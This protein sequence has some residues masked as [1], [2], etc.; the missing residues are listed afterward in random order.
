MEDVALVVC[1]LAG[2]TVEDEG[3]VPDAFAAALGACGVEVTAE[4]LRL[5][6]GAS[7]REAIRSFIPAGPHHARD[8]QAAYG[9][10]CRLLRQRYSQAGVRPIP[11]A[12]AIFEWLR[13]QDVR[14]ALNTGFDRDITGMLLEAL[15][16]AGGT[17][18]AVVCGDEVPQGRP[19]PHMIFRAMEMTGV[20][21]VRLVANVGDT[22][23]DLQAGHNAG[24]R[25][26]IGVLSGAHGQRTLET[27]PHTHILPS[28]ASLRDVWMR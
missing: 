25:W 7:K 12:L 2:A 14:V 5:V 8:A 13:K 28:I 19:A 18:D 16:W 23:F 24:V 1:D 27:A 22:A 3:Q 10:F 9:H 15:G 26:N 21:N 11:G 6:R 4:Q 17:V 20:A